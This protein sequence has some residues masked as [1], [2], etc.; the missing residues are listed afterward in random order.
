MS[1]RKINLWKL[2][3]VVF[4][5]T[6]AALD[7]LAQAVEEDSPGGHDITRDEAREIA[8]AAGQAVA[9]AVMRELTE[10]AA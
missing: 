4:S 5:A 8:R 3:P 1:K 10:E 2:L 6:R 9:D 7:E